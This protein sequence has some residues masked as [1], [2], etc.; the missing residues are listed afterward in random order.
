MCADFDADAGG[1]SLREA[2]VASESVDP[3]VKPADRSDNSDQARFFVSILGRWDY[4]G[5][6]I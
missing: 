4:R 6:L 2:R 3:G 1:F 5:R